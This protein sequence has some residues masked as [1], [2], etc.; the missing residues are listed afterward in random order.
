MVQKALKSRKRWLQPLCRL[1]QQEIFL[2]ILFVI[3]GAIHGFSSEQEIAPRESYA[4]VTEHDWQ[5]L[6]HRARLAGLRIFESDHLVLITDQ[7]S[8]VGDALEGLPEIFDEAVKVWASHYRIPL[9]AVQKWKVCGC[10]VVDRER[11]RKAGLLPDA[12]P[13]FVNGYCD[14]YRFW[15]TEQSNPAYQRHLLL[16]EGVHA[17]TATLLNLNTP[18]WYTEGIAEWLATHRL[19]EA[20]PQFKHAPIP[21]TPEDVEQLGRIEMIRRLRRSTKAPSLDEVFALKPTLHGTVSS[22]ASAWAVVAFL[23]GHP[24]YQEAFALT[25]QQPLDAGFTRRLKGQPGWNSAAARRDFDAF[26]AD[27]DYGFD[28]SRM[29]IN[30]SSGRRIPVAGATSTVTATHGWQNSGWQLEAGR[31]YQL[32]VSGHCRVGQLQRADGLLD[33]ESTAVGISIDW[34][35]GLPLGRLLIAQWDDKPDSGGRP[36]FKVLAE[37]GATTFTAVSNSPMFLKINN[38]PSNL[39]LS[40]GQLTVS[41]GRKGDS[42]PS[43]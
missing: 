33:L 3:F 8:R 5:R 39:S 6:I 34:Y 22:Y 30:W 7:A 27:L 11:F 42:F 35:R 1:I 23:A 20:P 19:V 24:R 28:C 13:D 9:S 37:G 29:T 38:R 18:T 26:T 10:L 43:R 31:Q 21:V 4:V 25:E 12:I 14:H 2:V 36:K 41:I 17:F 40:D 32:R 15:L 16:H